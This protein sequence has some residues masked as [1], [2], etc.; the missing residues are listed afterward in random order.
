MEPYQETY[1]KLSLLGRGGMGEVYLVRHRRLGVLRAI[2]VV[3]KGD[4]AK[5]PAEV[6]ILKNLEHQRLPRLHDIYEDNAKIYIVQDYV[7]GISAKQRLERDGRFS[8]A[9]VRKWA[10]Q[11]CEALKYL[12]S[13]R[14]P[15]IHRDIKPGNIMIMPEEDIKLIDFGIAKEYRRDAN[16]RN[17]GGGTMGYAAPEQLSSD[18]TDARTDI[19]SLGVTL[20]HMIT[21][22]GPYQGKLRPIRELSRSYSEGLEYII[23]KCTQIDPRRRYQSIDQLQRDLESIDDFGSMRERRKSRERLKLA[24]C[25]MIF[26][27]GVFLF[28]Y[29]TEITKT[30]TQTAYMEQYDEGIALLGEGELDA[31]AAILYAADEYA[32]RGDGHRAVAGAYME[33][34]NGVKCLSVIQETVSEYPQ[35]QADPELNYYW[36]LAL[37]SLGNTDEAIKRLETAEKRAPDNILY[38]YHLARAYTKN[39]QNEKADEMLE[40]VKKKANNGI[41]CFIY[42]GILAARGR[43]DEAAEQYELCIDTAKENEIRTAAYKEL[44]SL[45]GKNSDDMEMLDK[46]IAVLRD[47]QRTY[48]NDEQAFVLERLGEAYYT[49]S[50]IAAGE[51]TEEAENETDKLREESVSCFNELISLG[52]G[53]ASTYL[54]IAIVCQRRADYE[55]AEQALLQMM[56]KYP[57]NSDAYIQMAFLTAEREG[58]KPQSKRRYS[59]IKEYYSKAVELG[60]EG[61]KLQRLEGVMADLK[62]AGWIR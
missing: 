40:R 3:N 53:R 50:N 44:V 46:E 14:P 10:G 2:K 43:V 22:I 1:E 18:I 21:G 45:Y 15:I 52:Y 37:D 24:G 35:M 55:G 60:A 8:E 48:P 59:K 16:R 36:G 13:R 57:N 34:G 28:S 6:D 27:A 54:N 9:Q 51:G 56:D 41:S 25:F 17:E 12:H 23:Q 7:E 47:M 5:L 11:L 62:A 20:Y 31:A 29:G 42:A 19:Y 30:E 39:G 32:G 61:E 38:M 58:A 49:K 33:D 4:A 26:A